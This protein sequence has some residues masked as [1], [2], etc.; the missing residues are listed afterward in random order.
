MGPY[1]GL[2]IGSSINFKT[3]SRS[4]LGL[5]VPIGFQVLIFKSVELFLEVLPMVIF[6][7]ELDL[8]FLG[9]I[10]ARFWLS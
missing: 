8:D 10:G 7:L 2:G 3:F 4:K 5:R 9:A 6:I 1:F